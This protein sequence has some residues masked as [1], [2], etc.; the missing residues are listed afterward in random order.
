MATSSEAG[1]PSVDELDAVFTVCASSDLTGAADTG[2]EHLQTFEG[3]IVHRQDTTELL[4][5]SLGGIYLNLHR[6]A[7][8]GET[9]FGVLDATSQDDYECYNAFFE[10]DA[11]KPEL[12]AETE[13][14]PEHLFYVHNLTVD[15]AFRGRRLGV[16]LLAA[17]L[18]SPILPPASLVALYPS[19]ETASAADWR[20]RTAR[21][22]AYCASSGFEP[23]G[24]TGF[25]YAFIP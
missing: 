1:V 23:F 10:A 7:A 17:L 8:D 4:L 19:S 21:L 22:S 25:L 15:P 24:E 13:A 18:R 20:T 11:W 14:E 5:G 9:P 16:A 2:L 6:M 12:I 3:R